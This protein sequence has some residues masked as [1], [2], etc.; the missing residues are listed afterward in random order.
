MAGT[1]EQLRK[2]LALRSY[3]KQL[4]HLLVARYGRDA[5][6]T[7]PQVLTTIKTHR[8]NERY[9]AYACVMFCSKRAYSEFFTNPQWAEATSVAS[10]D[11]S[12][13]MWAGMVAADWPAH[14]E[15]ATELH[16][17]HGHSTDG[18][19]ASHGADSPGHVGNDHDGAY[20]HDHTGWDA[21]G[22]GYDGGGYGGGYDGGSSGN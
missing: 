8:L 11:T 6:Y 9:A 20:H 3:R 16:L 21:G 12:P 14:H 1:L 13:P 17:A 5:T 7:P 15:I 4:P 19:W 2:W 22:G 10:S 18:Q